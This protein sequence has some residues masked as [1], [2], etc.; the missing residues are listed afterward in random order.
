LLADDL[1]AFLFLP[2]EVA[3]FDFFLGFGSG[4]RSALGMKP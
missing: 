2:F 3:F 4:G 1:R